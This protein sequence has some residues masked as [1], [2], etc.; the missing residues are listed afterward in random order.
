MGFF[1]G[2]LKT[3]GDVVGLVTNPV[4]SIISGT[5][6]A[7]G[8]KETNQA[9]QQIAGENNAFNAEQA[10][11]NRNF[12]TASAS[13]AMDFSA[14]QAQMNRDYQTSMSNT[15][16][17]RAVGDMN[18]AGIN[19]MLAVSQGGAS[20]PS[21]STA[22]GIATAGSTASSSGNPVMG[23]KYAAGIAA[24]QQAVQLEN[25][26][27]QG[28]LTDAQTATTKADSYV[29]Q[30]QVGEIEARTSQSRYSAGQSDAQT[31]LIGKQTEQ[32][33]KNMDL[34][35]EQTRNEQAKNRLIAIQ[36]DLTATENDL[37]KG[38]IGLT[39]AQTR[40]TNILGKLK[41]LEENTMQ[42]ESDIAGST[43]GQITQGLSKITNLAPGIGQILRSTK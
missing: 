12:Q 34:L 2:I 39:Q 16:Y 33:T 23:N 17:Q 20:T 22:A 24:A 13:D 35:I 10:Q 26:V 11:L 31:Q 37:A 8:Q 28:K 32:V 6:G 19:P 25:Q 7:M 27:K 3:V 5:L 29:K 42:N 21:G 14:K 40:L 43:Y 41:G 18:A 15:A 36:V 30:A 38:K 9:N 4:G 1:D